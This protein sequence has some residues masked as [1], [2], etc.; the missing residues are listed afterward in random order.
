MTNS[1]AVDSG[2]TVTASETKSYSNLPF[3]R[4]YRDSVNSG[5]AY[6]L[7]RIDPLSGNRS[8]ISEIRARRPITSSASYEIKP[9]DESTCPF[10]DYA[11]QTPEPR[12]MHNNG[13]A[14]TVP[15]KYP[16]GKQDWITIYLPHKSLLS[17]LSYQDIEN[18]LESSP[19]IAHRMEREVDNLISMMDFTNWGVWAGASISHPHS[20]RKTITH[21]LDSTEEAELDKC[22]ALAEKYGKNPFDILFEHEKDGERMIYDNDVAVLANF[23]PTCSGEL[24]IYPKEQFSNTLQMKENDRKYIIQ[25]TLDALHSLFFYMGVTDLN[26]AI[27]MAPF[28]D[29]ENARKYYRWHMHIYPRRSKTPVDRA[30][31]ELGFDTDVITVLPEK[32]AEII[33]PWY[34]QGPNPELLVKSPDGSIDDKLLEEFDRFL[35]R[36][37][38]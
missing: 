31:A 17:Q 20:Q 21:V 2:K 15:N 13:S 7:T 36:P 29:M 6:I 24:L 23:A 33:R 19:E 27:H 34:T 26:V 18:M 9:V 14:V 28:K 30:G 22:K 38:S 25:P 4:E 8:I 11:R 5:D 1:A 3:L 12:I 35:S 10:C 32:T 16:F 37:N